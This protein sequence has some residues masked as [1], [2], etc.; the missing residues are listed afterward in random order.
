[1]EPN[2]III[3]KTYHPSQRRAIR[4][5]QQSPHGKLVLKECK[6]RY[7]ERNKERINALA[8]EKYREKK[9]AAAECLKCV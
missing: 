6:K 3:Y 8:R 4:K 1:M 7:Y 5:Y 9:E 2:V